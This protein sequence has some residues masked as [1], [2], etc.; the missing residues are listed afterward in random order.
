MQFRFNKKVWIY[1]FCNVPMFVV[2]KEHRENYL[3]GVEM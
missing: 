1:V 2:R 3:G